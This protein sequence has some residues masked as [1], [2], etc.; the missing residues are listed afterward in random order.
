MEL[1]LL[2]D[3]DL[4]TA[5]GFELRELPHRNTL[6]TDANSSNYMI[7][8][9][10]PKALTFYQAWQAGN[11]D[12]PDGLRELFATSQQLYERLCHQYSLLDPASLI[13]A[14]EG[15]PD[16]RY[17]LAGNATLGRSLVNIADM[18]D[19]ATCSLPDD[20]V[21]RTA[22]LRGALPIRFEPQMDELALGHFDQLA[23]NYRLQW[24]PLIWQRGSLWLGPLFSASEGPSWTDLQRRRIAAHFNEP[25]A[26]A[27]QRPST[28]GPVIL[29]SGKAIKCAFQL[30]PSLKPGIMLEISL[31]GAVTEHAVLAWPAKLDA[32]RTKVDPQQLIS[33]ECGIIRR[34]RKITHHSDLPTRIVTYQADMSF[35]QRV[36]PWNCAY[37]CEGSSLGDTDQAYFAALGESCER[38][39]GN[40]LDTLPVI[41]G[42]FNEL[43][44]KG[45]NA[46]APE[47]IVLFRDEEYRRPGFP[48]TQFTRDLPVGWVPAKYLDTD[49]PIMVPAAL[50]YSNWHSYPN[51]LEKPL[52]KCPFAGIA[53]GSSYDDAIC[54]AIEE[55][56]ERHATMTWWLTGTR[57]PELEVSDE[58]LEQLGEFPDYQEILLTRLEN[59]FGYPVVCATV[60]NHRYQTLN[61]GFAAR[62]TEQDAALK[63]LLEAFSLQEG[64]IDLLDPSGPHWNAIA[65]GRLPRCGLREYRQDRRYAAGYASDFSDCTDLMAQ[66]QYYLDPSAHEAVMSIVKSGIVLPLET[67]PRVSRT[68]SNY[69]ALLAEQGLRA[70]AVDLTPLDIDQCGIKVVRVIVPGTVMNSPA[71]FP[72]LGNDVVRRTAEELGWVKDARTPMNWNLRPLPHA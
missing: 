60:A 46:I 10:F 32:R 22:R 25:T 55:I 38:Y 35:I 52:L 61:M 26:R 43:Q 5:P 14:H 58:V 48:F 42:S 66:Q 1:N 16:A 33:C 70:I 62:P 3:F 45:L 13:G 47:S 57:L 37:T 15:S 53:A 49:E 7:E 39:A 11:Q 12:I 27:L 29:L 4:A 6:L 51:G 56:I 34:L 8:L 50:T 9:P 21:L 17:L 19:L 24:C 31:D 41:R 67:E 69:R 68:I 28:T 59:V 23:R 65:D 54:S 2:A 30:L 40:A 44:G 71:A 20:E 63:A 36:S 64:S 18:S 72:H